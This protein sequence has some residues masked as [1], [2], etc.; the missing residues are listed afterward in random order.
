MPERLEIDD[1]VE[2]ADIAERVGASGLVRRRPKDLLLLQEPRANDVWTLRGELGTAACRLRRDQLDVD[3]AEAVSVAG[4]TVDAPDAQVSRIPDE[5]NRF[6]GAARVR[7]P[8]TGVCLDDRVRHVEHA[9]AHALVRRGRTLLVSQTRA[10]R[11]R[12]PVV[13][14]EADLVGGCGIERERFKKLV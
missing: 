9:C 1:E 6:A 2:P 8:S 5:E 12:T 14:V 3:T 10:P 7:V 11:I 13:V 4:K